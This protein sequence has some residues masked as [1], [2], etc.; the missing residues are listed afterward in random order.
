MEKIDQT[1]S[2][3]QDIID[4]VYS[5]D[6]YYKVGTWYAITIN[7]ED[8]YQFIGKPDRLNKCINHMNEV[9]LTALSIY[10]ITYVIHVDISEPKE[11]RYKGTG[12]R[13]HYHGRIMFNNNDQL[14]KFL[15]Y[16]QCAIAQ[17]G[18]TLYKQIDHY[19]KWDAYCKKYDHIHGKSPLKSSG[20]TVSDMLVKQHKV[21]HNQK[22]I[23]DYY[24]S[25][26][27]KKSPA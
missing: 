7:P 2:T 1:A 10:G 14:I 9:L 4:D 22:S 5:I 25:E 19:D 16:G 3:T 23:L 24:P 27:N 26:A 15:L 18:Q 6:L 12:A 11:V 20:V 8:S 13:V 17:C 21:K